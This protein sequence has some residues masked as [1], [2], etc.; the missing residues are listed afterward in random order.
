MKYYII[1]RQVSLKPALF[2]DLKDLVNTLEK[3]V[4]YKF[5]LSRKQYMQNLIELGHGVDDPLGKTFT[6]AMSE[7]VDI[8]VIKNNAC[9]RC[10]IHEA[11]HYSKYT[12]EMG[13]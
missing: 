11:T 5:N 1:D 9:V 12:N 4:Q 13:H 6:E 3:V 2:N 8:G 10:N 7:H